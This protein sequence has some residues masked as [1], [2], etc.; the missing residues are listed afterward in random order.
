[1]TTEDILEI[2]SKCPNDQGI[3]FQPTMIPVNIKEHVIYTRYETGGMTGGGCWGGNLYHCEE[4]EPKDKWMVLELVL[5]KLMPNI[6]FLQY[7][8]IE[9]LI[10]DNSETNHTYYGNSTDWKVEYIILSELE[11]LILNLKS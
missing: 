6:T 8:K 3:F 4:D 9:R 2:N 10:H 7:K 11:Q 5:E 1:M